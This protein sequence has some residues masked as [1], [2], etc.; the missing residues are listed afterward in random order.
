MQQTIGLL[1]L[2]R[3][4]NKMTFHRKNTVHQVKYKSNHPL[5][6]IWQG[7]LQ[8][9][10]NPNNAGYEQYGARGITVCQRW[11]D[12][13]WNFVEDLGD[14]PTEDHSIDRTNNDLGYFPGNVR[15]ATW[16]EQARNRRSNQLLTLNGVTKCLQDWAAEYG[17]SAGA[18][19]TRLKCGWTIEK[20]LSEPVKPYAPKSDAIQ[21]LVGAKQT[22][23]NLIDQVFGRLKVVGAAEKKGASPNARW[24][25]ECTCGTTKEVLSHNLVSGRSTSCGCAPRGRHIF[26]YKFEGDRPAV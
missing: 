23:R 5:Y 15:Y 24:K 22:K 12:D 21:V 16:A 6:S 14:R 20:A 3:I 19:Y 10:H 9:C 2:L 25:C 17:I 8:R 13:F 1:L 11:R 26:T 7:M 18:L 4:A